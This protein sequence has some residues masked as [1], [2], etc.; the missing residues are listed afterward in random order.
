MNPEELRTAGN[1]LGSFLT[2]FGI[3]TAKT[4][5]KVGAE[6]LGT[7][8]GQ[9]IGDL[10]R[11]SYAPPSGNIS[12][13]D[14]AQAYRLQAMMLS[15]QQQL[16]QMEIEQQINQ[17]KYLQQLG[18]I[19]ARHQYDQPRQTPGVLGNYMGQSGVNYA[20]GSFLRN[21]QPRQYL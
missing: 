3:Q 19:Q 18:T 8:I 20:P 4:A 13:A 15:H 9:R 14:K 2:Q 7:V 16:Q 1:A 5:N 17:Q 6:K 11:S 10:A 21:Y 12:S